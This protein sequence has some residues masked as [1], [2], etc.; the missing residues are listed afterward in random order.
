VADTTARLCPSGVG[1]DAETSVDVDAD[2][3]AE[4]TY[5]QS[6]FRREHRVQRGRISSHFIRVNF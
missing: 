3:E 4:T 2:G 1:L 5:S 6:I